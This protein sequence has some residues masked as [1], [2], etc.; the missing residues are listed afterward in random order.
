M[1]AQV[2]KTP[3]LREGFVDAMHS[4]TQLK[5]DMNVNVKANDILAINN[6]VMSCGIGIA[7]DQDCKGAFRKR[8]AG[9]VLT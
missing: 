3:D 9:R 5:W 8:W 2:I 6:V 7:N 4:G 1:L